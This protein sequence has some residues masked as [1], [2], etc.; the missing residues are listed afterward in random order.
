MATGLTLIKKHLVR[1]YLN[2]GTSANPEWIQIKKA[3][4]FSRAMNPETEERDYIADEQPTTELMQ[5]KP[6]ESLT[7]TMYYGEADFDLFYQLYKE[8]ATGDEAKREFL[9]VYLFEE[10]TAGSSTYYYADKTEATITVDEFNSVDSTISITV[11]ENGTPVNGYVELVDGVPKFTEGSMP[12]ANNN[13]S[14]NNDNNDN[15]EE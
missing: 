9:L 15:N 3:T 4:E 11:Y 12:V 7:V 8:R 2:A 5:Y 13:N 14:D 1:P 6:S 10:T